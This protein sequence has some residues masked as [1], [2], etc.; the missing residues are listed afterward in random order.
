M[1][2]SLKLIQHHSTN[3]SFPAEN[4]AFVAGFAGSTVCSQLA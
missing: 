2:L 3:Q 1:D 4:P